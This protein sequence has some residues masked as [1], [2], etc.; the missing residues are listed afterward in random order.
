MFDQNNPE[1]LA[2]VVKELVNILPEESRKALLVPVAES[3]GSGS[4]SVLELLFYPANYLNIKAQGKLKML[5]DKTEAKIAEKK[6]TGVYSESNLGLA[7]K[8]IEESKYQLDSE[9][10]Q[11]F[12]SELIAN[13]LDK[14][15]EDSISPNFSSILSNLSH[16]DAVFLQKAKQFFIAE[17]SK[18]DT[19][20]TMKIPLGRYVLHSDGSGKAPYNDEYVIW[21]PGLYET[22]GFTL[23]T[24]TSFGL[25]NYSFG[26]KLLNPRFDDFYQT[27]HSTDEYQELTNEMEKEVIKSQGI[28]FSV[29]TGYLSFTELGRLFLKLVVI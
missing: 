11:D 20:N 18:M 27:L 8:A 13:S 6:Q 16:A 19:P 12:F 14:Q 5:H 10:L 4:S 21:E 28:T 23:A 17:G 9:I 2:E 15:F 7:V 26:E 25:I 24:L 3:F 29:D 22:S 1:Q